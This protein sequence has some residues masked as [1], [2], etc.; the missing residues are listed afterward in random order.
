[1]LNRFGFGEPSGRP[2]TNGS[3]LVISSPF[4]VLIYTSREG[5]GLA[6]PLE[7]KNP[8]TVT[9]VIDNRLRSFEKP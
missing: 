9:A 2:L 8:S 6:P 1:M 7:P 4:F 5:Q 3:A